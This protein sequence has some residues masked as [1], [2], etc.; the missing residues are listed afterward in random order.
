VDIDREATEVAIMSLYLKILDEGYDKGQAELFLRGHILPDMTGNIKC[1]NSLID[2]KQLYEM[3]MFG[4]EA[5]TPFDW[6]GEGV[7]DKSS[8]EYIGRGFPDIMKQGGFDCIVGNPPY[9][10]TQELQRFQPFTVEIYK[11]FYSAASKGNFDIYIIFI[12]KALN[13]LSNEGIMGYICPHKFFNSGY[14]ANIRSLISNSHGI[15]KILHFGINQIFS[16]ATTY[17]CLLFLEKKRIPVLQYYEFKDEIKNME[18]VVAN[19]E[20]VYFGIESSSVTDKDWIFT[21]NKTSQYLETLKENKKTLEEITT[22]IFQGP[23]AGADPVFILTLISEQGNH[24][25]FHSKSLNKEI[26]LE[27][28]YIKP[29]VKGKLIR[30]NEIEYSTEYIIFPYQNGKLISIAQIKSDSPETYNYLNNPTNKKILLAREEGRFKEIWWSY[31]RPQN[32]GVLFNKKILTPFNAFNSS[33]ALDTS[34]DFVFSAGVSGAYG[35]LLKEE[36]NISYEYLLA[37]LNSSTI[38]KFVKSISTALRGGF[39]S[40]ENKYIKQ[41]PIYIPD[42]S[43]KDRMQLCKEIEDIQKKIV[44]LG[45][46]KKADKKYLESVIDKLVEKLYG[47]EKIKDKN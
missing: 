28:Q 10:K 41:I 24:Y 35:I 22:N 45:E 44:L 31:S 26:K 5:I 2:R 14:G 34:C 36:Y 4:H 30:K 19:N 37:I 33:F 40:Y 27:R 18:G 43:D 7:L 12:E 16:N 47:L 20:F 13:L 1:G 29:Y 42:N 6:D 25:I 32:M 3:D 23:K 9:I 21:D 8:N 15:N 39:Y 46:S 17:T 11:R 38:E